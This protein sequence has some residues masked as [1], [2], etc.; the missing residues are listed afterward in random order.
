LNIWFLLVVA[1]ELVETIPSVVLE[2]AVVIGQAFL[3]KAL[4]GVRLLKLRS[5]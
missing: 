2:V 1:V 5:L 4:A 3:V